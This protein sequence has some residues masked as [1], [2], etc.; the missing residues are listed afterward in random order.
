MAINRSYTLVNRGVE[1][2]LTATPA[3][4]SSTAA[5]VLCGTLSTSGGALLTDWF[6][7]RIERPARRRQYQPLLAKSV[8]QSLT[9]SLLY[10]FVLRSLLVV[11]GTGDDGGLLYTD[12]AVALLVLYDLC[13]AWVTEAPLWWPEQLLSLATRRL[14]GRGAAAAVQKGRPPI[15]SAERV[16]DDGFRPIFV[17]LLLGSTRPNDHDAV[18]EAALATATMPSQERST[19][20]SLPVDADEV[21]GK[22]L[23]ARDRRIAEEKDEKEEDEVGEEEEA[24]VLNDTAPPPSSSAAVATS[25]VR[26]RRTPRTR[27]RARSAASSRRQRRP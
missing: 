9:G 23:T 18:V 16:G 1:A 8:L 14:S 3:L 11:Q 12:D 25:T 6:N 21:D 19:V 20:P 24:I 15:P 17:P 5:G 10:V 27:A 4:Q 7:L 2:A 22:P 26:S 13:I